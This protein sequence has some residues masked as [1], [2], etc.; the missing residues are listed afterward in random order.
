MICDT[1]IVIAEDMDLWV[2]KPIE[3]FFDPEVYWDGERV[4][5][6][7]CRAVGA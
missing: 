3:L 6:V 1:N 4:G 5:G 7:R 2:D